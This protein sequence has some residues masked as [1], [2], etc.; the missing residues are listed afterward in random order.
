MKGETGLLERVP[1]LM[2][3]AK[4][5][6]ECAERPIGALKPGQVRIRTEVS[7]VSPGTELHHIMGTHTK[8]STY[9]RATG[10]ISVGRIVGIGDGVEGL[11]IGLRVLT[12]GG[13]LAYS[14]SD[15]SSVL[16]VPDNVDPLDAAAV[17][18]LA[19][20]LRGVR[21]AGIRFGDS[22]AVFGLGMIGTYAV[23]LARL[24]GAF[25]VIGVDPVPLRREVAASLGATATLDPSAGDVRKGILEATGGEGARASI[26]ATG[27]TKVITSL[28]DVTAEFGR[29]V[30]LGG[31]HGPVQMDLY[32]R[33]QKGNLTMIGCGSAY[34]ADYPFTDARNKAVLLATIAAGIVRPRPAITHVL[35]WR[36]G[37]EGYRMLIEEKNKVIGVAFDWT[38]AAL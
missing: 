18:L 23:H 21:G 33:F 20:S 9:P 24:S 29:I 12:G 17:V 34:P 7:L 27:T 10:Y 5:K 32:S 37:P 14:N 8:S 4:N 2:V 28:P 26:D 36:K 31:I 15:A 19:I 11:G 3:T 6:V 38:D 13:H 16:A 30:V 35:P 22:V 25:P 1:C